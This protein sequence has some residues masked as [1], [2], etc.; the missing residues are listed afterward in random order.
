MGNKYDKQD[1]VKSLLSSSFTLG[2]VEDILLDAPDCKPI[3][4]LDCETRY[5]PPTISLIG[6]ESDAEIIAKALRDYGENRGVEVEIVTLDSLNLIDTGFT[7]IRDRFPSD[8]GATVAR[9]E[10]TRLLCDEWDSFLRKE[11]LCPSGMSPSYYHIQQK[12]RR[13]R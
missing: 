3:L 4:L 10:N 8:K 11:D 5:V 6:L 7:S 13:K 1:I 9:L 12:Q 2:S